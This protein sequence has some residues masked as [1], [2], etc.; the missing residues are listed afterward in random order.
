MTLKTCFSCKIEFLANN[1]NFFRHSQTKD[2]LHSWCK[3]CCKKGNKRSLAKKY[4]NFEGRITTFLRTCN[5][6]AKKRNQEF[7][8]TRQDFLD[9][10]E[11]QNGICAYSGI[12]M[13]LEPNTLKSVSVERVNND[14]G[15]I[16]ENTVL[17][18]NAINKMKSNMK[19]EDFFEF[20][21]QVTIWMS[22]KELNRVVDF[23][24]H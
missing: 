7:A 23:R 12:P 13:A 18:T 17:V 19:G 14:I 5:T 22:D 15:Y 16:P 3:S 24:K 6:S 20:C 8:L 10:W 1:E 4:S 2:G 11:K 9:M 21:K